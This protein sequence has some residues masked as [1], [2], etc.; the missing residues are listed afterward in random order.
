MFN[1]EK[2]LKLFSEKKKEYNDRIPDIFLSVDQNGERH[3][4]KINWLSGKA[5]ELKLKF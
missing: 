4:H 1:L 2:I 5:D 3:A